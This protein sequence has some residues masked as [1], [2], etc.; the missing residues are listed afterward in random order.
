[1]Q[2]DLQTGSCQKRQGI[3]TEYGKAAFSIAAPIM[4]SNF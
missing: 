2:L 4:W 3:R 1:M